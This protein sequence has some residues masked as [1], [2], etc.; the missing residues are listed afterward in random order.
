M[1]F[2]K[3]SRVEVFSTK[4]VPMGAWLC[5]EIISGNGHTYSVQYGWF[6]LNEEEVVVEKVARKVIRPC[7]PPV[8]GEVRWVLG[9]LVEVF[10]D[11]SWKT[12]KIVKAIGDDNF[13]V[14]ILGLS[15]SL[16]V[17]KSHLRVRQYWQD[18][19][20][21]V[22]GKGKEISAKR[23]KI[24]KSKQYVGDMY[25][26]GEKNIENQNSHMVSTRTLKRKLSVGSYEP[27]A[28]LVYAPKRR[29]IE[30]RVSYPQTN[31]VI[32]SPTF[33][34]VDS[35]VDPNVN[36]GEKIVCSSFNIATAEFSRMDAGCGS[37]SSLV[38]STISVQDDSCASSVG[39]CSNSAIGYDAHNLPLSFSS[40]YTDNLGD[41]CSDAESS[42]GVDYVREGCFSF[43]LQL[44][45]EFRKSEQQKYCSIVEDL[46]ASGPLSWEDEEK[47]TNL[48]HMLHISDD[49]HLKHV[50]FKLMNKLLHQLHTMA[51]VGGLRILF[52]EASCWRLAALFAKALK[53]TIH[54][55]ILIVVVN[56]WL[57][58]AAWPL[59]VC[60][61]S[62]GLKQRNSNYETEKQAAAFHVPMYEGRCYSCGLLSALLIVYKTILFLIFISVIMF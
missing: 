28:H 49:E 61:F 11:C 24:G 10:D 2:T 26:H 36:F 33:E 56:Q 16:L 37:D 9:D 12:A 43:N 4:Y 29:Q 3:G 23:Q 15:K 13:L 57:Y 45:V 32:P 1:R 19:E 50:E 8:Q 53:M 5:A 18:G 59:M 58:L 31:S 46:Y 60:T 51:T 20:W 25:F 44:G 47:L 40:Q 17:H 52:V 41:Y 54:W 6:P 30:K 14:R 27:E 35:I 62:F 42:S 22:I 55:V 38:D 48:R 7:P 39:S 34:K 21:I